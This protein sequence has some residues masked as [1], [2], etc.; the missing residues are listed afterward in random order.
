MKSRNQY[1]KCSIPNCCERVDYHSIKT[2]KVIAGI[3]PK[4]KSM[5]EKHRRKGIGRD[6]ANRWKMQQG[7]EN[8]NGKYGLA[9][10]SVISDPGQLQI[11]HKDGNN[12]NR[13]ASN[14]EVLCGNCHVLATKQNRHHL[15]RTTQRDTNIGNP[16]LFH[17]L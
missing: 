5:C 2:N 6:L 15:P 13:D 17:G 11:N 14:I 4:W 1:V 8:K 3:A 9:C 16:K 12:L 7:C 10:T